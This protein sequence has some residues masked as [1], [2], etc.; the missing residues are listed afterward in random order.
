MRKAPCLLVSET[1]ISET[2]INL[3]EAVTDRL[4]TPRCAILCA[5]EFTIFMKAETCD[6][7]E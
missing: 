5:Q 4:K 6:F 3:M 1:R 2:S 7:D